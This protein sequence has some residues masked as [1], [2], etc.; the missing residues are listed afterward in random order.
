MKRIA[1]MTRT[2]KAPLPLLNE[3]LSLERERFVTVPSQWSVP[4][5][6][7]LRRERTLSPASMLDS[8]RGRWCCVGESSASRSKPR[9]GGG[10]QCPAPVAGVGS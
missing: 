8:V 2:H 5:L 9:V 7:A 3:P 4:E 1:K 10:S 6:L